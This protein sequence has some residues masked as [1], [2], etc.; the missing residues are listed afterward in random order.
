VRWRASEE[1]RGTAESS[2]RSQGG[3]SLG[4]P[5]EF[6]SPS[7]DRINQDLEASP[8]WKLVT[9]P[10]LNLFTHQWMAGWLIRGKNKIV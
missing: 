4:F 8:I 6:G 10:A 9:P 2:A 1:Y 5:E 3:Y 7:L